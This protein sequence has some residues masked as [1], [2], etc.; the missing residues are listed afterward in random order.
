MK[1]R[2]KRTSSRGIPPA[3]RREL[4]KHYSELG[5]W[6]AVARRWGVSEGVVRK[7]R[8]ANGIKPSDAQ[9]ARTWGAA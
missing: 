7:W 5:T 6:A 8:A 4:L 3:S 9:F 1:N 2:V